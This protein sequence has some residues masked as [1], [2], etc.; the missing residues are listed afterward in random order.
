[1]QSLDYF[2]HFTKKA[3]IPGFQ[4]P[5]SPVFDQTQKGISTDSNERMESDLQNFKKQMALQYHDSYSR[6]VLILYVL[7]LLK[8]IITDRQI[9]LFDVSMLLLNMSM[10][11]G[12]RVLFR[13][14]DFTIKY[15]P[16]ILA[17]FSYMSH[18]RFIFAGLF[19]ESESN[20]FNVIM[21]K[22]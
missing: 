7:V 3:S 16:Y 14:N 19:D 4:S 17:I 18:T 15:V 12:F 5:P 1:M 10:F 13:I 11:Y 2:K 22:D 8:R 21:R 20:P 9:T 6:T